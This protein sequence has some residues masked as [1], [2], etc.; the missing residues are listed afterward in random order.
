M[1][2]WPTRTIGDGKWYH[3]RLKWSDGLISGDCTADF[4]DHFL[5]EF[6]VTLEGL[7]RISFWQLS[8]LE[9]PWWGFTQDDGCEVPGNWSHS[10]SLR[11]WLVRSMLVQF[12]PALDVCLRFVD[13]SAGDH[14]PGNEK[15]YIP[16]IYLHFEVDATFFHHIPVWWDM[17]SSVC[18]GEEMPLQGMNWSWEASSPVR[19]RMINGRILMSCCWWVEA[20]YCVFEF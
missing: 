5:V 16:T 11:I 4:E 2:R 15:R 14:P 1:E 8:E 12:C 20:R 3:G 10:W 13:W 9:G 17:F 18:W 7:L 19:C 6:Q